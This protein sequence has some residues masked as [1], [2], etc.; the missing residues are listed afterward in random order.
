MSLPS[1]C[2]TT[3]SPA[4][5]VLLTQLSD[6]ADYLRLVTDDLFA[7]TLKLNILFFD[8]IALGSPDLLGNRRFY[9]FCL[10]EPKAI[11]RLFSPGPD[12]TTALCPTI[13][14]HNKSLVEVA[15]KMNAAQTITTLSS[16]EDLLKHARTLDALR[17]AFLYSPEHN[18]RKR[19]FELT[20]VLLRKTLDQEDASLAPFLPS[21]SAAQAALEWCETINDAFP[22][23]L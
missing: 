5:T 7:F 9:E 15:E 1:E 17:P 23:Q 10:R 8:Q 2:G 3:S 22:V 14:D 20:Q 4:D 18:Y 19:Y 16:G 21:K 6:G 11:E 12:G 13:W